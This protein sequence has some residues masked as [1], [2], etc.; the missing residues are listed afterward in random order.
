[1]KPTD[2]KVVWEGA[3]TIYKQEDAYPV[4]PCLS[5]GGRFPAKRIEEA[6]ED[7]VKK[8]YDGSTMNIPGK[9]RLTLERI[10]E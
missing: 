5:I 7:T 1:M 10:D 6:F 4:D 3:I 9:W 2:K 8:I